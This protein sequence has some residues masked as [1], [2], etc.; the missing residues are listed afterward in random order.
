MTVLTS[1]EFVQPS[2]APKEGSF[3]I[4]FDLIFWSSDTFS[5]C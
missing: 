4:F 3:L 5:L 2:N 1:M